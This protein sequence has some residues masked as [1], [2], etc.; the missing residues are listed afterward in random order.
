MIS[1][2]C[3]CSHLL[4]IK[5]FS[6]L[7]CCFYTHTRMECFI[8]PVSRFLITQRLTFPLFCTRSEDLQ[9]LG[10]DLPHRSRRQQTRCV[11]YRVSY[12]RTRNQ[13]MRHEIR[14][15]QLKRGGKRAE[16][17]FRLSAKRTSSFKS[18]GASVQSTTGSR[19]VRISGSNAGYTMF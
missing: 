5:Y 16:Y 14:R 17:R 10:H 13:T 12:V 15:G 8:G 6:M 19:G 11:I 9:L 4:Y 3:H 18:A 1:Q 2:Y 7:K